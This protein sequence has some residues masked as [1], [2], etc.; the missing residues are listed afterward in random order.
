VGCQLTENLDVS[1]V[2]IV[3]PTCALALA[4]K[5]P[6]RKQRLPGENVSTVGGTAPEKLAKHEDKETSRT[7]RAHSSFRSFCTIDSSSSYESDIA[8]AGDDAKQILFE[9]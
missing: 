9:K 2:T 5:R 1:C 7:A 8:L 6:T 4:R 3:A